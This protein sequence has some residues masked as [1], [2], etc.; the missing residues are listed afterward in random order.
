MSNEKFRI[1]IVDDNEVFRDLLRK[2]LQR[3]FPT[4]AF[5]EA[6]NGDEA[7]REVDAFLPN[8]IFM[9]IRLPGEDGTMLT[10]KIKTT[11]P[12]I[13]IFLMTFYDTPEYRKDAFQCGADRLLP[14]IHWD[15]AEIDELIKNHQKVQTTSL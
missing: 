14:K 12:D 13:I 6:T 15:W 9:D 3:S 5:E 2:H 1:L 10:K 7:L 11:H 4:V 8:L